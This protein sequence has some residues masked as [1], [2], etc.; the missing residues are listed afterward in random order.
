MKKNSEGIKKTMMIFLICF[1]LL[2]SYLIFYY[3]FHGKEV[4]TSPLNSRL[5]NKRNTMLRGEIYDRNMNKL[6]ESELVQSKYEIK[7][8]GGEAFCH[9]LG[10]MHPTYGLTGLQ[11]VYD[12][13]LMGEL[14]HGILGIFDKSQAEESERGYDLRTTLN[15]KLQK[16]IFNELDDSQGAVV[17]LNPK[18]GE[19]LSMISKPSYNPNNID[20]NWKSI[21]GNKNSPLINRA[22]SGMYPPASTFKI[23]TCTA[24]LE[25]IK[26]IDN[27]IID[28]NGVLK[29][30][31]VDILTNFNKN[32]LGKIGIKDAFKYSSN[33][34]FGNIGIELGNEKL[35]STAERFYFNQDTPCDGI[36][37]DN[38]VFP[39]FSNGEIGNL[40]QSAI[41]QSKVLATPMEMAL[42]AGTIANDGVMIKPRLVSDIMF[43]GKVVKNTE[44]E[45][46]ERIIST[47]NANKIKEY[48]REVVKS[49]TGIRANMNNIQ[50]CGKTGTAEHDEGGNKK[51]HSW[52]VGF[53]P[54]EDP[55]IAFAILV[56]EAGTG[57]KAASLS[58]T[59]VQTAINE[60]LIK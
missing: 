52:F 51:P 13:E 56:E 47:K 30:N 1:I 49:G 3:L 2:I 10:Y 26:D 44:S 36:V 55:Q 20:D 18:S 6:T 57:E 23:I 11:N 25:S 16:N 7:Y 37:I 5:W 22:V 31:D 50:V 45:R 42:V 53:A 58:R 14:N 8:I 48:M 4:A 15:S 40:A 59:I 43:E 19:I 60:E 54:Y 46:I 41:G 33:V 29:Y 21:V 38:S 28:D 34:Y 39:S 9:V 27:L 24:A 17:V 35:K 12:R 32:A